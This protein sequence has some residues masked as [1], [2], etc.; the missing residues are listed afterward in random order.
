MDFGD[1]LKGAGLFICIGGILLVVLVAFLAR[2]AFGSRRQRQMDPGDERVW[3]EEG[4]E[5]PRYDSDQVESRGGFGRAPSASGR[6]ERPSRD[7]DDR[8]TRSGSRERPF[9]DLDDRLADTGGGQNINTYPDRTRRERRDDEDDDD[10]VRS[11]GGFG[12]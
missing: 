8:S 2:N 7:L 6:R 12:G 4:Q 3:R 5:R 10:G 11:R 9:R 1:L